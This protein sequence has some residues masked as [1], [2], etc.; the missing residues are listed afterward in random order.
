M[1]IRPDDGLAIIDHKWSNAAGNQKLGGVIGCHNKR[2][3]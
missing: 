3:W 1:D 2:T